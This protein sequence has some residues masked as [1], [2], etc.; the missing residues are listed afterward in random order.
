M[1]QE[2]DSTRTI[3]DGQLWT[4]ALRYYGGRCQSKF[5]MN[6]SN[7]RNIRRAQA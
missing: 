3:R 4:D 2:P 5:T 1:N 6:R 7:K